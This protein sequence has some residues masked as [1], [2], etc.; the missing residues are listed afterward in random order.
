[1][2]KQTENLIGVKINA[3]P[4]PVWKHLLWAVVAVLFLWA[5][6]QIPNT[7][8]VF[9]LAWLIAYLLNPVVDTLQGKK[10]GPIKKCSRGLAVGIITAFLIGIMVAAGSWALP[11]LT[12]QVQRLLA[13]QDTISDPMELPRTL[14]EKAEPFLAKVPEAYREQA[15]EKAT[16]LIQE[17]ASKIGVWVSKGITW[18]GSFLGE[19]L[20]GIFLVGTAFL[21][22]LYMLMNWHGMGEAFLEKLPKQYRDEVRSLSV[23]MN[24]IFGAYL[25][26]T[27]LT[28]L[29]CMVATF[30][31]LVILCAITGN[32]F[33]YKGLV[34]F[35]A[36]IAY[37][38][39]VVGIIATSILGGVLGYL[40]ENDLG[41]GFVV[42]L[43]I[44]AVNVLIDRTVQPKLMSNAIGV[45]ELFVL[46]AAFAGGEIAGIWGMLLGI[47]V[48]AMGKALFE[49]FHTNFLVVEEM[50]PEELREVRGPDA[51]GESP[52]VARPAQ[53]LTPPPPSIET[54]PAP[55]E[56]TPEP[57]APPR[58][59]PE[60]A[61][62]TEEPAKKSTKK[63]SKKK[64]DSKPD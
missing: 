60:P 26:A 39:P 2:M 53:N 62:P 32:E 50:T 29:A 41:F 55:L 3:L 21:V 15:M 6:A 12:D 23:K 20:S 34:A 13:L 52:G 43:T 10:L 37:P 11:H 7:L 63:R 64:K 18:L 5:L 28:S 36:G 57:P 45:S 24:E 8:I 59:Q 19:L 27:I 22:S 33:P 46:F 54:E 9:S 30:V 58:V 16:E 44:N 1:M 51:E 47:P 38:V 49:W 4:T 48:A 14:R 17:S 56:A 31:S 35:V 42:L 40:P 61:E 25:N